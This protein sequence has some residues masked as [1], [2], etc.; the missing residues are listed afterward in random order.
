MGDVW[1]R[2]LLNGIVCVN[3]KASHRTKSTNFESRPLQSSLYKILKFFLIFLL[4]SDYTK[5]EFL[6]QF[7][8]ILMTRKCLICLQLWR[9]YILSEYCKNIRQL[10]WWTDKINEYG[11]RGRWFFLRLVV[12][13]KHVFAAISCLYVVSKVS[14][15]K[16]L[17]NDKLFYEWVYCNALYFAK[18]LCW[19]ESTNV[20]T[21]Q[22]QYIAVNTHVKMHVSTRL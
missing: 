13:C 18:Y 12:T 2:K 3:L 22:I 15:S 21:K 7:F 8:F 14:P 16:M 1:L 6:L 5:E 17:W 10:T 11:I 19:F 4:Y 20:S 9:K